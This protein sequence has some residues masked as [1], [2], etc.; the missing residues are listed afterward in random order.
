MQ[1]NAANSGMHG[2]DSNFGPQQFP[3]G[4]PGFRAVLAHFLAQLLW[5]PLHERR[6]ECRPTANSCK[7]LFNARQT[8]VSPHAVHRQRTQ[9]VDIGGQSDICHGELASSEPWGLGESVLHGLQVSV[10]Q[11]DL[12]GSARGREALLNPLPFQGS[13][14]A[15]FSTT[16][17]EKLL[18]TSGA[19]SQNRMAMRHDVGQRRA[20]RMQLLIDCFGPVA[21]TSALRRS[22]GVNGA[23]GEDLLEIFTD[24]RRFPDHCAVVDEYRHNALWIDGQELR[25]ELLS[26]QDIHVAALP[27]QSFFIDRKAG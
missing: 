5:Y 7:P 21:N 25:L 8:A 20:G 12:V 11:A 27:R 6:C 9:P 14:G 19:V 15:S 26:A 23:L 22:A 10:V 24:D 1:W 3:N 13:R 17:S 4:R 16:F 18:E 2:A